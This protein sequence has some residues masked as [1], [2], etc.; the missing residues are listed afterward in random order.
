MQLSTTTML[1]RSTL[2]SNHYAS[3]IGLSDVKRLALKIDPSVVNT[4]KKR[5]NILGLF[6][7]L[8]ALIVLQRNQFG[9]ILKIKG[10]TYGKRPYKQQNYCY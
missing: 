1:A 2:I 5:Q 8:S 10:I 9:S 3:H 4:H 6:N 7:E